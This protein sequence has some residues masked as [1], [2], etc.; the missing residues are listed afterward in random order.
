VMGAHR[1]KAT[2][3]TLGMDGVLYGDCSVM[4]AHR[5]KATLPT[6]GMDGVLYGDC[7]VMGAHR[8]KATLPTLGVEI[9]PPRYGRDVGEITPP[10]LLEMT[11]EAPEALPSAK[12]EE[13]A[14][15]GGCCWCCFSQQ[16]PLFRVSP[17]FEVTMQ[18][19]GEA[20]QAAMEAYEAEQAAKVV[21]AMEAAEAVEALEAVEACEALEAAEAAEACEAEPAREAVQAA[22]AARRTTGGAAAAAPKA[23]FVWQWCDTAPEDACS[24]NW[25]AYGAQHAAIIEAAWA[26]GEPS[27][28]LYIGHSMYEVGRF[29][30][31]TACQFNPKS[32]NMRPVRRMLPA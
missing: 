15:T 6:L 11:R 21:E 30:G 22:A 19:M 1:C 7:S 24:A 23:Q 31:G 28:N 9:T 12:A 16:Q 4:G 32:G 17:A 3:P 5:C 20:Q 14:I 8:C 18:Q 26:R 27:I 29:K 2:L 13:D 10:R 25:H